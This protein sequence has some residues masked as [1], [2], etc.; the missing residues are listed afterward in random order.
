MISLKKNKGLNLKVPEFLCDGNLAE[1]LNK[2]D[3]LQN[4]NGF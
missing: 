2:Y 3:M 4:F 1:H